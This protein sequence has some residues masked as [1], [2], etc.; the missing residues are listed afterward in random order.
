MGDSLKS[1]IIMGQVDMRKRKS[2]KGNQGEVTKP[3]LDE[4]RNMASL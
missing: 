4:L 2:D 1:L 3:K